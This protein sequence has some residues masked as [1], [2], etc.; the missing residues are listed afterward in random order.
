M[1]LRADEVSMNSR[2][3]SAPAHDE[4][5]PRLRAEGNWIREEHE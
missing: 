1:G 5:A 4:R 2:F 3:A